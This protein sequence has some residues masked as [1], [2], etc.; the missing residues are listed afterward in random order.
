MARSIDQHQFAAW[1]ALMDIFADRDR[2]D[3]IVPALQD[4]DACINRAEIG[5]IVGQEGGPGEILSDLGIGSAKA[6]G[7][8]LG[9]FRPIRIA[10]DDRRHRLRPA[11]MIAV[12][13]IEQ[14]QYL[15]PAEPAD[16]IAII[17]VA[18]VRLVLGP[19]TA[20]ALGVPR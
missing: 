16:I 12:E 4:Q 14:L 10:H 3:D 15:V 8:F 19:R 13:E 11:H 18:G 17:D 2:R 7:Q 9:E 6:V 20:Q 5:A 1:N